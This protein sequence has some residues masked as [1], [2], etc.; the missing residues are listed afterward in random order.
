MTRG[1]QRHHR[2]SSV[3]SGAACEAH[4]RSG[5]RTKPPTDT[6][7]RPE[8]R[9]DTASAQTRHARA[10][11]WDVE[12]RLVARAIKQP[13]ACPGI[14][15]SSPPARIDAGTRTMLRKFRGPA[16]QRKPW[17]KHRRVQRWRPREVL[18][19]L[20]APDPC[21]RVK[22]SENHVVA[23]PLADVGRASPR[24]VRAGGAGARPE[25]G[26]KVGRRITPA[27]TPRRRRLASIPARLRGPPSASRN[28]A[29][30]SG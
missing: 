14:V 22:L 11:A 19:R 12:A 8:A 15:R 10:C 4:E 16:V 21:A 5:S 24:E 25:S 18:H 13:P 28:A 26:V 9:L 29:T 3:L 20:Q 6:R 17:Q 1:A 27:A 30:S 2:R 7:R 23:S